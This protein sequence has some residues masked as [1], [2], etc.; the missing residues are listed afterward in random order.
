MSCDALCLKGREKT[1]W[2]AWLP[3]RLAVTV[4]S[5]C[6]QIERLDVAVGHLMEGFGRDN[7]AG[8]G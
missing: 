4:G 7:G 3:A 2:T 8:S 1:G 6:Q 5:G